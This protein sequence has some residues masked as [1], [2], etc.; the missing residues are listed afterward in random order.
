[1][2]P[3]GP[4]PLGSSTPQPQRRP[5][6]S[7][8][9]NED[10]TTSDSASAFSHFHSQAQ[11]PSSSP[12]HNHTSPTSFHP[13][14]TP[15][16]HSQDDG[17]LLMMP[18]RHEEE[19]EDDAR[20]D[21]QTSDTE[22]IEG[23][24]CYQDH[25][26]HSLVQHSQLSSLDQYQDGY[27]SDDL[28]MSDASGAH[29]E[30]YLDM[31]SLH[32]YEMEM[33]DSSASST[34]FDFFHADG[35]APGNGSG[36]GQPPIPEFLEPSLDNPA[37]FQPAATG[38]VNIPALQ[39]L[40]FD[41][42]TIPDDGP[43]PAWLEAPHPVGLTNPNPLTLGPSNYGLIDFLR[44]W[45]RDGRDD[46][47]G[48]ARDRSS[49]PWPNR[50]NALSNSQDITQVRYAD[51][52]GDQCDFQGVDWEDL[53]VR[54]KEARERRLLTYNNYVNRQGSDRWTVSLIPMPT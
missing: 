47:P 48:F 52:E 31:N 4:E 13:H 6:R 12:S 49:L 7:G 17:D 21:A 19:E 24:A 42:S 28:D 23:S 14:H 45:A 9:V 51:L 34:P 41:P 32:N 30:S 25:S 10:S 1:M 53:G 27:T 15:I 26:I 36:N 50:V 18:A 39:L 22:A 37:H 3:S 54:R 33:D 35:F 40:D 16:T 2:Y 46:R 38:F 29:L 44:H 11:S 43:V 8:I 20:E 5:R